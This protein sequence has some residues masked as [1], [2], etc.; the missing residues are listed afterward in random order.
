MKFNFKANRAPTVVCKVVLDEESTQQFR[1][2]VEHQYWYQLF[3]DDLPI[4]G[5][6]GENGEGWS[7]IC[8]FDLFA[9]NLAGAPGVGDGASDN[10]QFIYTHSRFDIGFNGDRIIQVCCVCV[11]VCVCLQECAQVNAGELD[12]GKPAPNCKGHNIG[13]FF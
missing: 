3:F 5:M 9:D 11:C 4:W 13:V 6:V 7:T 8:C 1:Y 10:M 2:A 12:C